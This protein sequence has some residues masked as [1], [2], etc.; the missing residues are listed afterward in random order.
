MYSNPIIA[1]AVIMYALVINL[2]APESKNSS[3]SPPRH[4][5]LH[6]LKSLKSDLAPGESV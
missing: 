5:S 3:F 1:L 4:L 2:K 6:I